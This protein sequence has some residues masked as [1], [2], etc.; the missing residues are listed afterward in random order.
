[1]EELPLQV[2]EAVN[3]YY[4]HRKNQGTDGWNKEEDLEVIDKI[5]SLEGW[6]YQAAAGTFWFSKKT[7]EGKVVIKINEETFPNKGETNVL[8]DGEPF[9]ALAEITTTLRKSGRE[10]LFINGNK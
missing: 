10:P 7:P 8:A 6:H 9:G 5:C 2:K 4:F 1:M 3:K